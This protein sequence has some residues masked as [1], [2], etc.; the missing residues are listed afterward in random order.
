MYLR[1]FYALVFAMLFINCSED[2]SNPIDTVLDANIRGAVLRTINIT[3]GEF[4]LGNPNSTV[5]ITIEE[6]DEED[7]DLLDRVD[8][9]V[10]Y[11]NSANGQITNEVPL[12]I[13]DEEE[14]ISG[15]EES[16]PRFTLDYDLNTILNTLQIPLS[17]I[18][19]KDQ[20]LIRLELV[21]SDGRTLSVD[22]L[23]AVIAGQGTFFN[24]PFCYTIN[25]VEPLDSE[26]FTGTYFYE[27]VS[28][29][30][31]G[32][33]FLPAG[34]VQITN[35]H[36]S[37]VRNVNLRYN[38]AEPQVLSEFE[39]SIVCDEV[40]VTKLLF[41]GEEAICAGGGALLFGPD[42]VNAIVNP[43][44]DSVFEVQ[45][46]EGFRGFNGQCGFSN[47]PSRIRFSRQ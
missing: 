23:S 1:Y 27:S 9:F 18:Q 17:T 37:T 3:E 14:F 24:S 33:T 40:V 13:I 7:G 45:F 44:D 41:A 15:G 42:T 25:I 32:P 47:A 34:L 20:I 16:L 11:R 2:N 19:C 6:K 26:L 29:G 43:D 38:L 30:P 5:S 4:E 21:L 22:D 31:F 28:D 36:S 35:G 12:A 10:S 46:V 39:F 8:V